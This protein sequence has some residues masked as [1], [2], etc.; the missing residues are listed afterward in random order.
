MTSAF[1]LAL[2]S[3]VKPWHVAAAFGVLSLAI[4]VRRTREKRLVFSGPAE[5]YAALESETGCDLRLLPGTVAFKNFVLE[6]FGGY[7]AGILRECGGGLS[8]HYTGR[9]WDWGTDRNNANVAGL[10]DLLFAR[11]D[12]VLRRAGITY[13]IYN[14]RIWNTRARTWQN[15]T[16]A[17]AH[18][19]H[20]H[21]SFSTAGANGQTSF[22]R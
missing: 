4:L 6:S 5:G 14:R 13:L 11:N 9:S 8:G 19:T 20:V 22:Y 10:F 18:T 17:D 7:D 2:P 1:P 12:E 21:F 15:Y 3:A 16:G